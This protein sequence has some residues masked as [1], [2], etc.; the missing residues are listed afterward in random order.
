LLFPERYQDGGLIELTPQLMGDL[1]GAGGCV[2][3]TAARSDPFHVRTVDAEGQVDEL[4]RS[5]ELLEAIRG[6]GIEA[7]IS[8]VGPGAIGI[9]WKLSRKGLPLVCV[10]KSIE[11]DVAATSA[12]FGFN[13]ALSFVAEMLARARQAAMAN[14]RIG[15]I[16]VLGQHAGWLALQS[17][18]A[19]CA[20][21]ALIPEIPYDLTGVAARLRRKAEAGRPFGLVVVAE[22]ARPKEGPLSPTGDSKLKAALSPLATG[23]E[24]SHVIRRAGQV[25]G[26]VALQLQKLTDQ[27]VHPLVLGELARGGTPTVVDV[28][29]GLGYGAGAVSALK[30]GETGVLVTYQPPDLKFVPMAEAI[31]RFRT[32]PADSQLVQIARTL[33]ISLGD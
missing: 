18:I 22:G 32:V 8:I 15:V 14:R 23:A 17:A 4:D 5:D 2:L 20:D 27:E 21:G 16:E 11:N 24:S 30:N 28:Q 13:S 19:V 6:K 3:G 12:S 10:P 29:L 7:V 25:A 26:E 31:N 1:A 33:G 9:V